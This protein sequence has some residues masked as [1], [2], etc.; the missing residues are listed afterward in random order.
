[1]SA[2]IAKQLKKSRRKTLKHIL[3][4]IAPATANSCLSK[5]CTVAVSAAVAAPGS[6]TIMP[7]HTVILVDLIIPSPKGCTLQILGL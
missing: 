1:V 7:R 6:A 4:D 3:P 2:A 5:D